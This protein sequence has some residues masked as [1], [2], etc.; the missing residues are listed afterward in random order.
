ML[1]F[2]CDPVP[3]FPSPSTSV[4]LTFLSIS[5]APLT[6]YLLSSLFM[7]CLQLGFSEALSSLNVL[8]FLSSVATTHLGALWPP[9][10]FFWPRSPLWCQIKMSSYLDSESVDALCHVF[11]PCLWFPR[12]GHHSLLWF[13]SCWSSF[14]SRQH[15]HY[16]TLRRPLLI[17]AFVLLLSENIP[18]DGGGSPLW[19]SMVVR[20]G[21]CLYLYS[22]HLKIFPELQGEPY[23]LE[24]PIDIFSI[25]YSKCISEFP[26]Y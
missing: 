16:L 15:F 2:I 18:W 13:S 23:L 3:W 8:S 12:H 20:H 19:F 9:L 14:Q 24:F 4:S 7:A 10:K 25:K 22:S 17:L 6:L 5:K 1:W 26:C 11:F 21:W